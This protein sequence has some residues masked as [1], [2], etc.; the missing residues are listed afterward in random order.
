MSKKGNF[1][2][3]CSLTFPIY[4]TM[5]IQENI[6]NNVHSDLKVYEVFTYKELYRNIFFA[7]IILQSIYNICVF[8]IYKLEFEPVICWGLHKHS[9]WQMSRGES[10]QQQSLKPN[11]GLKPGL[12]FF[13]YYALLYSVHHSIYAY[14]IH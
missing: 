12:L 4:C 10:I 13:V 7:A 14:S 8:Y 6:K 9:Q 1:H 3:K 2:F 11:F 5:Y